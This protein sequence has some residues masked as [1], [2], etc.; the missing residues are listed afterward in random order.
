VSAN[1]AC[2]RKRGAAALTETVDRRIMLAALL[3]KHP[4]FSSR[5][6][7]YQRGA[8]AYSHKSRDLHL[9]SKASSLRSFRNRILAALAAQMRAAR[10]DRQIDSN[11]IWAVTSADSTS[12]S[13]RHPPPLA[14]S[15]RPA[16]ETKQ[17]I[18]ISASPSPPR[19]CADHEGFVGVFRDLPPEIPVVPESHL[20][21][22]DL[23]EVRVGRGGLGIDLV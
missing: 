17:T 10:L 15:E 8:L 23:L 3:A 4:I 13:C 14:E 6:A 21:I 16:C 19:P 11:V 22:V 2:D 1:Q 12:R 18:R 20:R 9:S 5:S 7:L